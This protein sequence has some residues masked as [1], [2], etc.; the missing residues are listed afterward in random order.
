MILVVIACSILA[1]LTKHEAVFIQNNTKKKKEEKEVNERKSIQSG[2]LL[3]IY[4]EKGT[5][6]QDR[7]WTLMQKSKSYYNSDRRNLEKAL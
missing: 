1:R 2:N 5:I 3:F 4:Q 6:L 7:K